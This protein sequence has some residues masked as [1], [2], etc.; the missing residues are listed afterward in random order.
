MISS[1]SSWVRS[2]PFSMVGS[3]RRVGIGMLLDIPTRIGPDDD[4]DNDD[5]EVDNMTFGGEHHVVNF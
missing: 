5:E 4:E 3:L 2:D 1:M